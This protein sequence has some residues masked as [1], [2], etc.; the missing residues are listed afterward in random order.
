MSK[1][2]AAP[3]TK[4]PSLNEGDLLDAHG[5][6]QRHIV[7]L[8]ACGVDAVN[9]P[10]HEYLEYL[11]PQA[12]SVRIRN[13]ADDLTHTVESLGMQATISGFSLTKHYGLSPVQRG[14]ISIRHEKRQDVPLNL[15][16]KTTSREQVLPAQLCD[17]LRDLPIGTVA[18][19]TV[20]AQGQGGTFY[21]NHAEH[22]GIRPHVTKYA[23]AGNGQAVRVPYLALKGIQ[24][25]TAVYVGGVGDVVKIPRIRLN[26]YTS[27]E[28]ND[29]KEWIGTKASAFAQYRM[30]QFNAKSLQYANNFA[31]RE[32]AQGRQVLCV[33]DEI[34]TP[35]GHELGF[36]EAYPGGWP[37]WL[38]QYI[39]NAAYCMYYAHGETKPL[40]WMTD[41]RKDPEELRFNRF[42]A[43]VPAGRT[44]DYLQYVDRNTPMRLVV[45]A[46]RAKAEV[47]SNLL[48]QAEGFDVVLGIYASQQDVTEIVDAVGIERFRQLDKIVF[49]WKPEQHA[50]LETILRVKELEGGR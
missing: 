12:K 9:I 25:A 13:Y 31:L 10:T 39:E 33:P 16:T 40:V 1:T 28:L 24:P 29:R 41:P 8:S 50:A 17:R 45:W 21:L 49:Y 34:N 44:C 47:W 23:I 43:P 46:E 4:W 36:A 37:Q 48:K 14:G 35:F 22:A 26:D 11:G 6:L 42:S 20:T 5:Q 2:Y 18:S 30:I 15:L 27:A 38:G 19:V 7:E 32:R 3:L